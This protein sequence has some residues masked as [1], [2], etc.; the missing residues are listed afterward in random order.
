MN[1]FVPVLSLIAGAY[2]VIRGFVDYGFWV[3]KGPGGGFLPVIAGLIV[4]VFSIVVIVS[5]LKDKEP[6]PFARKVLIPILAMLGLG[7]GCYVVGMIIS[8]ALFLFCW[9]RFAEKRKT[10]GSLAISIITT[11]ILY[12]IFVLWLSVPMPQGVLGIL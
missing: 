12:S 10:L 5:N 9:L 3:R 4:V 7:L 6:V 8:M 1:M 11:S 2:W